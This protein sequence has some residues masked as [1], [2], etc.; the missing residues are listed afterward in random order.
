MA[1]ALGYTSGSITSV[2][3]EPELVPVTLDDDDLGDGAENA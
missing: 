2:E 1:G 3:S